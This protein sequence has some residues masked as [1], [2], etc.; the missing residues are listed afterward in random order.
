MR[1]Q[2]SVTTFGQTLFSSETLSWESIVA[3]RS[4]LPPTHEIISIPEV[5]HD[6]I[7]LLI[8]GSTQITILDSNYILVTTRSTQG[9]IAIM[10]RRMGPKG[11]MRADTDYT[12]LSLSINRALIDSLTHSLGYGD[13]ERIELKPIGLFHDPLLYYLSLEL[14]RELENHSAGGVLFVESVAQTLTLHLLRR[15]SNSSPISDLPEKGLTLQQRIQIDSYIR[16]HLGDLR[17]IEELAQLLRISSVHLRRRF[18]TAAGLPLWQ[19]VIRMRVERARDLIQQG[20][21]S[22]RDIASEVGFA[23][24]SH[25]NRHF[26][27]IYGVSPRRVLKQ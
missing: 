12:M 14:N 10:P 11:L 6:S 1:H 27:R 20:R 16:E 3:Q 24:Q 13:P 18:Q 2:R 4:V 8:E 21:L 7:S 22:L 5:E 26:K 23:D 9:S 25:L 15:Y 17:S 19:H